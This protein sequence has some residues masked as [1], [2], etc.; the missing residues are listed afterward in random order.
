MPLSGCDRRDTSSI[1]V[2]GAQAA[3]NSIPLYN[4]PHRVPEHNSRLPYT[5]AW[6]RVMAKV[7]PFRSA[8]PADL[9][10]YHCS[11]SVYG[12]AIP[13]PSRA[14]RSRTAESSRT[15]ALS[16]SSNASN[17]LFPIKSCTDW[18]ASGITT[19]AKSSGVISSTTA[20]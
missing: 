13:A 4:P 12:Q 2:R 5:Q 15:L 1:R 16:L 6:R 20:P 7:G 11:E 10:V 19:R 17:T 18:G 9:N 14:S 3:P 8:N